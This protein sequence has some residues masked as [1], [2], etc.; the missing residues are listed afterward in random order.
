MDMKSVILERC[1]E[2]GTTVNQ[3]SCCNVNEQP[4]K[5]CHLH[6]ILRIVIKW[7]SSNTTML[8]FT[9]PGQWLT[10]VKTWDSKS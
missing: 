6:K 5:A 7:F 4:N 1:K 9:V 8:T 2:K 10:K 3:T